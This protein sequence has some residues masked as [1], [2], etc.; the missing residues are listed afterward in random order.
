MIEPGAEA[1]DIQ[2]YAPHGDFIQRPDSGFCNFASDLAIAEK[3]RSRRG[4]EASRTGK[5]IFRTND[6]KK[7]VIKKNV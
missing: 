6:I 1:D 7:N 4:Q 5:S 2:S 3:D